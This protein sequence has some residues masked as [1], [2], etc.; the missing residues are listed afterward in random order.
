MSHTIPGRLQATFENAA[1]S[2]HGSK[3]N[4]LWEADF[5]PWD[6]GGP[7]MALLDVMADRKDLI[8]PSQETDSASKLRKKKALVP[9]CGKGHDVLLLAALGYDVVGLDYAENAIKEAIENQKATAGDEAYQARDGVEKGEITWATGDFWDDAWLNRAAVVERQFDLVFDYTVS[10]IA[11][12]SPFVV[13]FAH[14]ISKFLCA[15]PPSARP[16]WAARIARLLSPE[17]RLICLEFPSYK[18]LSAPGPPWGVRPETYVALLSHPG[19]EVSYGDDSLPLPRKEPGV[20]DNGLKRLEL[21][22]PSRTHEAGYD[23]QGKV[24]DFIS[25]WAH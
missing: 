10:D 8:P 2:E 19:K 15:L 3:W 9:G 16:S 5:T 4:R 21:I 7:S 20:S 22:K 17:G 6:R 1:F 23:E 24:T 11:C 14:A 13:P 25:V 18:P 12:Y